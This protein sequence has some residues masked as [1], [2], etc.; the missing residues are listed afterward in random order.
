MTKRMTSA[1]YREM[2]NRDPEHKAQTVKT[3]HE[4]LSLA[5][6]GY[7]A[8]MGYTLE[9]EVRFHP[10]R[11]WRFDFAVVERKIG[12]EM[13]GGAFV[14]GPDGQMGGAHHRPKGRLRD[15]QKMREANA[16]GWTVSEFEWWEL[17]SGAVVEWLERVLEPGA[18]S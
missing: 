15:A 16:L 1:E 7:V 13:H 14:R 17:K 4:L 12:I 8:K 5:L 6:I 3:D 11:R 18:V 9:R 2:L 10:V